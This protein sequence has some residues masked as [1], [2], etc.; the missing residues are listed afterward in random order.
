MR[1]LLD[2]HVFL[3]WRESSGRLKGE[4]E[5]AISGADIVFV[6]A[7]SAWEIAIK[8]ALKK[9]R[10]PGPLDAAVEDSHFDQLPISFAHA[11]A[12]TGLAPHHGDPFDRMLIA[13]ALVEELTVV[14]HDRR[15]EAYGVPVIWV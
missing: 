9:L 14:T 1:L 13:Q 11:S 2:T 3:W 10:I 5:R 4:A 15:F 8:L 12:V 6:S 7:A